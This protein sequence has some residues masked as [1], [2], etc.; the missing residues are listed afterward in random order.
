MVRA[1]PLLTNLATPYVLTR[2]DGVHLAFPTT[3]F[4]TW[5]AHWDSHPKLNLRGVVLYLISLC[6]HSAKI[7]IV[8]AGHTGLAPVIAA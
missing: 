8:M 1:F 5:R 7:L 4:Q 3:S 6:A 2:L